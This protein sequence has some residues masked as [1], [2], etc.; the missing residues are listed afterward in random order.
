MASKVAEWFSLHERLIFQSVSKNISPQLN[1]E[2][3][4][5]VWSRLKLTVRPCSLANVGATSLRTTRKRKA[6]D[7]KIL[8]LLILGFFGVVVPV[9]KTTIVYAARLSQEIA[10]S[11]ATSAW[12]NHL[13]EIPLFDTR[14][15]SC[16][17]AT[18]AF[19]LS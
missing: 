4:R 9:R 13:R 10:L 18:R 16:N 12:L 8:S 7:H 11:V 2:R 5:K 14:F 19:R 3:K 17:L 1:K 6:D 15:R